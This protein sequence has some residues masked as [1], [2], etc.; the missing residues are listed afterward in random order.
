[1]AQAHKGGLDINPAG[2]ARKNQKPVVGY[3]FAIIAIICKLM[4]LIN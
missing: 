1:M 2:R 4:P 3:L